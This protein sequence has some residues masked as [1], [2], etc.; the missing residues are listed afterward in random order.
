MLLESFSS[1]CV[2]VSALLV[3]YLFYNP[4]SGPSYGAFA[5]PSFVIPS[6]LQIYIFF[7]TSTTEF[8][9]ICFDKNTGKNFRFKLHFKTVIAFRG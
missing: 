9:N 7:R 8:L 2:G 5:S 3:P 4:L 6:V 1:P